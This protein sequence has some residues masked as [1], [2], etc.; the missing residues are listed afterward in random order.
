MNNFFD[1]LY[2]YGLHDCILDEIVFTDKEIAFH[3]NSG[4]YELNAVGRETLLTKNCKMIVEFQNADREDIFS[5][6]DIYQ[7]AYGKIKDISFKDFMKQVEKFK[8]SIDMQYYSYFCNSI[9][10]KGYI[11]SKKYEITVCNIK[12]INFIF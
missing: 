8:F 3:F 1:Y 4:V 6:I 7:I 11:K 9:L 2:K 10:L 12:K 5:C